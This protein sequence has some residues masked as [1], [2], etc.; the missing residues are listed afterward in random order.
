MK[1]DKVKVS[2]KIETNDG[3]TL[4][5]ALSE[6]RIYFNHTGVTN[7]DEWVESKHIDNYFEDDSEEIK[8]YHA[9]RLYIN[10]L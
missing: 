4:V 8:A 10:M 6:H 1:K 7:K 9:F 3:E 5:L 2:A